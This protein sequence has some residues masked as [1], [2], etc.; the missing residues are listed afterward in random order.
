MT[1]AATRHVPWA[2]NTPQMATN[3]FLVYLELREYVWWL[4]MKFFFPSG[5]KL[6]SNT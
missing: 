2:L 4:Q 3:A 1:F 6:I 5:G